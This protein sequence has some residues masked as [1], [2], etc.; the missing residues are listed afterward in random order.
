MGYRNENWIDDTIWEFPRTGFW[1]IHIF[2]TAF[3]FMLGMRVA[4]GRMTLMPFM[5][6]RLLRMLKFLR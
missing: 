1:L 5:V 6:F 3:I 4:F 2:G